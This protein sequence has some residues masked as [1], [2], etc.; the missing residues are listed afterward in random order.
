MTLGEAGALAAW[1]T[2]SL[3]WLEH[4]SAAPAR[5][6]DPFAY[7]VW[8]AL[9]AGLWNSNPSEY[10]QI[11][12]PHPDLRNGP[13]NLVMALQKEDGFLKA[14]PMAIVF[15]GLFNDATSAQSLRPI[16]RMRELGFH[17]IGLPSPWGKEFLKSGPQHDLGDVHAEA[18]ILLEI[19]RTALEH[20][21]PKKITSYDLVGESYGGFLAVAA[22][23]LWKDTLPSISWRRITVF[24]TPLD[25]DSAQQNLDRTIDA[26]ADLHHGP[27][28]TNYKTVGIVLDYLFA[29]NQ[30]ELGSRGLRCAAAAFAWNGFQHKLVALA[31]QVN[32]LRHLRLIPTKTYSHWRQ[33]FRFADFFR[34]YVRLP[35]AAPTH[36][37]RSL[38]FWIEALSPEDRLKLRIL[39]AS[40][41]VFNE[42]LSWEGIP[43]AVVLPWGGHNGFLGARAFMRFY[44]VAFR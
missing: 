7:S 17:V 23:S 13:A 2:K 33:S 5:F 36:Q 25:L 32:R 20:V 37:L 43:E 27:C 31:E 6:A 35:D 34:D 26:T 24:G 14:A 40:D 1:D 28:A 30:R 18:S 41:D 19:I 11:Q 4:F 44:A 15:P 42:S 29:H 9:R 10:E 16:A 22:G 39:I 12:V 21:D 8:S 3:H 38:R